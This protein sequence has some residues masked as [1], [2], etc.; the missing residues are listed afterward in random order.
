MDGVL[1][2]LLSS[3]TQCCWFK[4]IYQIHAADPTTQCW[5]CLCE[6]HTESQT[7]HRRSC[8]LAPST[9]QQ[10]SSPWNPRLSCLL[11]MTCH[12]YFEQP[13]L[14][15]GQPTCN[16]TASCLHCWS[17]AHSCLSCMKL[18]A[19]LVPHAAASCRSPSL[20]HTASPQAFILWE[21]QADLLLQWMFGSCLAGTW[22][23]ISCCQSSCVKIGFQ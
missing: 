20:T 5:K 21:L 22:Q 8:P 15:G 3:L 13:V 18:L 16:A 7:A 2:Q 4:R 11:F 17:W 14:P 6:S 23:P 12:V 19:L 10:S 9:Q 1:S